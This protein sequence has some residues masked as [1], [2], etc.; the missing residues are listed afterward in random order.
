MS[1][2]VFETQ[3]PQANQD[4]GT[5]AQD[6]QAQG[7]EQVASGNNLF[8]DQ[9]AAIK[10]EDGRQK[11]ADV[12]TAL[13]S[14]PHA[15]GRIRELTEEINKLK[16]ENARMRGFEEVLSR[17]DGN[18]QEQGSTNP[19]ALSIEDMQSL[20]EQTLTQRERAASAQKNEQAVTEALVKKFGDRAKAL[21]Q[22]KA[23]AASLGIGMEVMQNLAQT[24]PSAVLSYFN[25]AST[26]VS[27]PS[28]FGT[29]P[30]TGNTQEEADVR[31]MARSKLFGKEDLL[32]NK[33]KAA[34]KS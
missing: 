2:S 30:M 17:L 19:Q 16:E 29:T 26:D 11:Y 23:K 5:P 14:I 20:V 22:L 15:Q 4:S 25:T 8:T 27:T 3:E 34:A 32:M 6:P 9:L 18:S 1:D 10:A 13:N 12:A 24:S 21:E 31:T 28:G 7:N 33:W